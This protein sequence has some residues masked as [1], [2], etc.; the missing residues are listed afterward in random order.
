MTPD[1][2]LARLRSHTDVV[3]VRSARPARA[4]SNR[5]IL[6]T[7][8]DR[9]ASEERPLTET[10]RVAALPTWAPEDFADFDLTSEY[11]APGG[12]QTLRPIQSTALLWASRVGGLLAPIGVGHGKGLLTM[13]L[14]VAMKAQRPILLLPPAM[15]EPFAREYRKFAPHWRMHAGLRVVPYSQLSVATGADL[16]VRYQPD[17]IIADEAHNLRHPT[18]TRTKRLL[19][20]FTQFPS[21]RFVGLSGTMT[22]KGLRDYAHLAELALGDGSPLPLDP[23]DLLA[24]ANCIDSDGVPTDSDWYTLASG[25]HFLPATWEGLA[26]DPEGGD[27]ARRAV[28]RARFQRRLTTTPGVVATDSASVGASLVFIERPARLP[29]ELAT[30]IRQVEA[31]WCRPDGEE[32]DSPLAKYRLDSQLSAGFWYRWVWPNGEPDTAWVEARAGWHRTVRF[33]LKENREGL[34]SPLLVTRA[35]MAGKLPRAEAAWASWDRQRAKPAPPTETVWVSGFMIRDAVAWAIERLNADEPGI[36]WYQDNAVGL[37]LRRAGLPVFMAGDALPET[38]DRAFVMACSAKAFGT[39]QNLQSWACNLVISAPS[40]ASDFEQL[41]GRTHRAGQSADEVEI[42]YYAHTTHAKKTLRGA[43]R[44]A[45]YIEETTGDG[46]RVG[47]GTWRNPTW[48]EA[49][50]DSE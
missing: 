47:Y 50:E 24:W 12:T 1:G 31:T 4:F 46:Q 8:R 10:Q 39:G 29:P 9:K 42:H 25:E 34:D 21:T 43:M 16:L 2:T 35:V 44:Q 11:R 17:L 49:E 36:I 19:R 32:M 14:P 13:I 27:T 33:I 5:E 48:R 41:I 38:H 30:V 26:F 37:A 18:A 22:R 6:A 15:R 40:S 28:A 3:G 23:F 20:Y 45:Q 7:I